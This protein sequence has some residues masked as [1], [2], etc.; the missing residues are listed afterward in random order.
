MKVLLATRHRQ[1]VTF[2]PLGCGLKTFASWRESSSGYFHHEDT[3]GTKGLFYRMPARPLIK[4]FY[5]IVLRRA[6]L[7][8]RAGVTYAI[9]Q[10]IYEYFIVL[11]ASE[12][13]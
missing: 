6:F 4:F 13:R 9:L 10:S 7:D 12:K 11:K 1:P 3:K 2:F 8:G 5:M